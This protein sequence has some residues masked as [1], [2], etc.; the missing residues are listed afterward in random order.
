MGTIYSVSCRDCKVT[1]DL[2][3]FYSMIAV[4]TRDKA[5]ELAD[6]IKE[7][8]SFRAALLV[9][10]MWEHAGHNCTVFNEHDDDLSQQCDPF[11]RE[12]NGFRE[13][14]NFWKAP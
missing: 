11:Y 9:S 8:D 14:L 1:R 7:F 13:D 12:E 5:I 6:R 10:F 4:E 3:K 2:D